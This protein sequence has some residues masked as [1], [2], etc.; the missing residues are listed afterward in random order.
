MRNGLDKHIIIWYNGNMNN[1]PELKPDDEV[2]FKK[3][4]LEDGLT[5]TALRRKMSLALEGIDDIPLIK[6]M[7]QVI[8]EGEPQDG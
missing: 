4:V 1:I 8:E 6:K 2:L 3:L 7:L 5:L